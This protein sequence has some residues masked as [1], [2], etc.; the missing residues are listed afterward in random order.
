MQ[1]RHT[2]RSQLQIICSYT[3]FLL[4]KALRMLGP[5]DFSEID[6]ASISHTVAKT[7]DEPKVLGKPKRGKNTVAGLFFKND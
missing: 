6:P 7:K 2:S 5:V 3:N 1:S 4:N